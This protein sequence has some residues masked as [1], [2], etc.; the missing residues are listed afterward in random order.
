MLI[1]VLDA[2]ELQQPVAMGAERTQEDRSE[3]LEH[4]R[5]LTA[6]DLL[7]DRQYSF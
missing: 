7:P 5:W 3:E 4:V 1:V 2:H 6:E